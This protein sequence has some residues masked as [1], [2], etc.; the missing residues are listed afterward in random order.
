M[1]QNNNDAAGNKR[2]RRAKPTYDDVMVRARAI[3]GR[4]PDKER[5][6]RTEDI[7]FRE[8]FGCGANVFLVLWDLLDTNDLIPEDGTMEHLLWTLMFCKLYTT[9]KALCALA[10]GVDKETFMIWVVRFVEAM[11]ILESEVV[12]VILAQP[13]EVAYA[14]MLVSSL[15]ACISRLY[16]KTDISMTSAMIVSFQWMVQTF[17]F[18][19]KDGYFTLS[20]SGNLDCATK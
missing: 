10:G 7:Q 8:F 20:S 18:R 13:T 12:S 2:K 1:M 4:D 5:S 17:G 11:E 9:Q 3:W 16:L 6:F 15:L 19:S 14:A